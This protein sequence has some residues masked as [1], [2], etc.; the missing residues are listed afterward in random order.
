MDLDNTTRRPN[1]IQKLKREFCVNEHLITISYEKSIINFFQELQKYK[2]ETRRNKGRE[3]LCIKC[4]KKG[5]TIFSIQREAYL[6]K[7]NS[8]EPCELYV[9]IQKG[10]MTTLKDKL[11]KLK[12]KMKKITYEVVLLK[13][14][15]AFGYSKDEES[16]LHYERLMNIHSQTELEYHAFSLLKEECLQTSLKHL[17]DIEIAVTSIKD[18]IRQIKR[19][20]A[21]FEHEI[22]KPQDSANREPLIRRLEVV[23]EIEARIQGAQTNLNLQK[24]RCHP[25]EHEEIWVDYSE[26]T[27]IV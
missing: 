18:N 6:M 11:D 21:E 12:N 13:Y 24:E 2:N 5:G 4:R 26:K 15:T 14:N 25:R 9:L 23:A 10:E 22:D 8:I 27:R 16:K 3:P 20:F 19:T 1:S 17:H 7:C